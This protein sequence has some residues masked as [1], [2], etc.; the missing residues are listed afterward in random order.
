MTG[1]LIIKG[2][3]AV[4]REEMRLA[5]HFLPRLKGDKQ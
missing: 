4:D 2:S 1:E 5:V 3:F